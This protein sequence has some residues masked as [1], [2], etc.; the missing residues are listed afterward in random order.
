MGDYIRVVNWEEFQHYKDRSP[1]WIKLHNQLLENFEFECLP[2]ASKAHLLC[3][4][5]LASRTDN[6]MR[7]DTR[8]LQRKICANEAVN[9]D[10]LIE[11]GF[12]EVIQEVTERKQD[13][14]KMLQSTEQ[15]A[16]PEREGE[17][18]GEGE[19]N[20]H[21]DATGVNAQDS[22]KQK[23]CQYEKIKSEYNRILVE[24]PQVEIL[25]D[26][27]KT[28]LRS[29]WNMNKDFQTVQFWT[30]FF[31]YV[32]QSDFLMGRSNSDY[33]G[34]DFDFL[35]QKSKFIKTYEGGYHQ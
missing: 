32:K 7:A 23:T 33:K 29:I 25:S 26:G 15:S 2:D 10:I 13:A 12:V 20:N 35:L 4:W 19:N 1:P 9:I 34:C 21:G 6:K 22:D 24:R 30:D 28:K 11:S 27:R 14:S 18:E 8:W 31:E 3:I 16:I 17:T 5:M